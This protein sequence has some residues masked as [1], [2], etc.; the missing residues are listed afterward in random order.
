LPSLSPA[1][2][3]LASFRRAVAASRSV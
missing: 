2:S 3:T 1:L